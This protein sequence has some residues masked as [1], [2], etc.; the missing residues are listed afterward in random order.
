MRIQIL[1]EYPLQIME[2]RIGSL[3]SHVRPPLPIERNVKQRMGGPA[4]GG[5]VLHEVRKRVGRAQIGISF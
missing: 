1:F 4:L 5:A 2:K 3:R